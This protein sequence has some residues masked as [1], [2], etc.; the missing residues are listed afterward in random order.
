MNKSFIK[1]KSEV[2]AYLECYEITSVRYENKC[3]YIH[4]A[5]GKTVVIENP[6]IALHNDIIDK[7]VSG[8][9]VDLT[10]ILYNTYKIYVTDID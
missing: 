6:R 8:E 9:P 7:V 1:I 4:T 2:R 3:T 10:S 5:M